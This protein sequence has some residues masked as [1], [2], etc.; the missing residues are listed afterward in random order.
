MRTSPFN[1][2]LEAVAEAA[3]KARVVEFFYGNPRADLVGAVHAGGALAGW[4]VGSAEEAAAAEASG[5]DYVVVP[6]IEAGGHV[7]GRQSLDEVLWATRAVVNVPLV[8]AGGVATAQRFA[9][10]MGRQQV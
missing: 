8:A 4:Q 3:R 5:C 6:G 9:R 7:R 10:R 2:S 1:P